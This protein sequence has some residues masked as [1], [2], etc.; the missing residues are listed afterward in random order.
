MD[1]GFHTDIAIFDFSK[2]FVRTEKVISSYLF[3]IFR[4]LVRSVKWSGVSGLD[5]PG[6][7]PGSPERQRSQQ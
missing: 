5:S 3:E 1:R 4:A 2:A 7:V 6:S